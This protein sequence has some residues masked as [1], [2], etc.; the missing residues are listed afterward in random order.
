[1]NC[2][3][4][5]GILIDGQAEEMP[6]AVRN[7][8]ERHIE[9][10]ELC[11]AIQAEIDHLDTLFK[12]VPGANPGPELERQ[13]LQM[14]QAEE[15]AQK[16]AI[17]PARRFVLWRNMAASIVL[18]AAGIGIGWIL[19]GRNVQNPHHPVAANL[20]AYSQDT[21][22]FS[23]LRDESASERIKAV[24]FA[25]E[26]KAPDLQ[27]I[28]ALINTLDHDKNANV[29]LACL[30]SLARF[31][32]NPHV[33]EALSN[34]LPRQTEP[35]VQIVLINI[36]TEMKERS[37]KRSLQDIISNEKTPKEVKNIAEK[38]LRTM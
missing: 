19:Y 17:R 10:C 1:M 34:S 28:N 2:E 9:N 20:P 37:V 38:G 25:E 16:A 29:R 8:L 3:E 35:I 31:Q 4:A 23:L 32:D 30:Y 36:L 24:N 21:L 15:K 22:L 18:V 5:K 27:V 11:A 12:A 6:H 14:L 26:M 7:A 13:F 33:R